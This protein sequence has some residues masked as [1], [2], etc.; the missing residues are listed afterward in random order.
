MKEFLLRKG[1]LYNRIRRKIIK[2]YIVFCYF[3]YSQKY[4]KTVKVHLVIFLFNTEENF[5]V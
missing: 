1:S 4:R 2:T 3:N 5:C